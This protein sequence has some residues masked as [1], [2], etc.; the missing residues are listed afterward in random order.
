MKTILFISAL[1]LVSVDVHGQSN[2]IDRGNDVYVLFNDPVDLKTVKSSQGDAAYLECK[3]LI[4][5]LKKME[6]LTIEW[7]DLKKQM[8]LGSTDSTREKISNTQKELQ[9][10]LNDM[11]KSNLESIESVRSKHGNNA[12]LSNVLST[13]QMSSQK[14]LDLTR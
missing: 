14:V 13:L 11:Y 4:A 2:I 5:Q 10:R 1:Y 12:S 6:L 9:V 7:Q 8:S 3:G